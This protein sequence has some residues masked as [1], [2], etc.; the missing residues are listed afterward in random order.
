MSSKRCRVLRISLNALLDR[1]GKEGKIAR[2]M[3]KRGVQ[4]EQILEVRICIVGDAD[5]GKSTLLG[6]LT[7]GKLDNGMVNFLL[8][9]FL[10]KQI[11]I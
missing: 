11:F 9:L 5:S 2:L 1:K 7:T 6:V 4:E 3:V 10:C 8:D